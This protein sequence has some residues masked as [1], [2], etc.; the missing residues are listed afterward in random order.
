MI[1]FDFEELDHSTREFMLEEFEREENSGRPFR[2]NV[3]SADGVEVFPDLMRQAIEEGD[4][5]TLYQALSNYSYWKPFDSRGR[6][7]NQVASAERLA[8]TEFN[9]WYVRGLAS[10]LI[11]EGNDQ[12]QIYR[13]A[14]AVRPRSEC[15]AH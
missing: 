10:R 12:C 7:V 8:I 11:D 2:G 15:L 3:L 6:R 1:R 9:T 4:E 14:P 5:A 13:A